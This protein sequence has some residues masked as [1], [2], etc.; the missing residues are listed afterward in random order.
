MRAITRPVAGTVRVA[1]NGIE[2]AR[3]TVNAAT[4]IVT[5]NAGSIP[6]AGAAVTAGFEFDVP[7]RFDTDSLSINLANFAAGDIPEIPV[8]EIRP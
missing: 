7:A 3:F 1:V 5:F 2:T 4:G 6:A 8:V